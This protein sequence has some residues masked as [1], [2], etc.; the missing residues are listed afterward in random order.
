MFLPAWLL[1]RDPTEK[2]MIISYSEQIA[3]DSAYLVRKLLQWEFYQR[4]FATRLAADRTRVCDFLTVQGGGLYAVSISGSITG[5]G[6]TII[7]FDDPLAIAD[8]ANLEKF[9]MIN[10]RFEGEVMSRLDNPI[11]GRA[12]ITGH[13]LHPNDLSGHVLKSGR[14]DHIALPMIAPSEETYELGNGKSW[15]CKKDDLLRPGAFSESDIARMKAVINPDFEA[16]YQQFAGESSAVNISR[17]CFRTF[18][19][20]PQML[21]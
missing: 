19:S 1:A 20:R 14:W 10:Q 6:A 4:H 21:P 3:S 5:R 8:C 9:A 16:L 12:L 7:I 17:R 13:R 15:H 2:I 18:Q 11:T